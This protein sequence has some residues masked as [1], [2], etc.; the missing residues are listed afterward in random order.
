MSSTWGLKSP[1]DANQHVAMGNVPHSPPDFPRAITHALSTSPYWGYFRTNH[2]HDTPI[3]AK[4]EH[5][6]LLPLLRTSSLGDSLRDVSL[7]AS[8]LPLRDLFAHLVL[9]RFFAAPRHFSGCASFRFRS[10]RIFTQKP[11]CA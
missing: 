2:F 5:M 10:Y 9:L 7:L 6:S 11:C 8:L 1:F 4:C 3:S